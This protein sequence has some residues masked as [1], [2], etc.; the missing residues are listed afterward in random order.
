MSDKGYGESAVA[1]YDGKER[2]KMKCLT[3][4]MENLLWRPMWKGERVDEVSD[5]GYGES[6]VATYDGKERGKMKCLTKGISPA[7][8]R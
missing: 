1:T 6:A 2:G 4:G 8:E 5:Q 7:A 3:K